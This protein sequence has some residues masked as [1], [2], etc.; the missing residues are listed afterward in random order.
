MTARLE[1]LR[2]WAA[3]HHPDHPLPELEVVAD[4]ASFRRYFRLRFDNGDSRIL[5][6]APPE[7]ENS[8]SFVEIAQR[9]RDNGVRVPEL[10]H[11]D[12]DAGFIELQDLGND[13][14]RERLMQGSSSDREP[15][16]AQALALSVE[17]AGQCSDRLPVMDRDWL[18]SELDLF[19]QWC[20]GRWLG[21]AGPASWQQVRE[22]LIEA[23]TAQPQVCVHRDLHAQNLMLHDGELWV[24][25]FQGAMRGPLGYDLA[26]LLRDRNHP[27]SEDEQQRWIEQWRLLA[28]ERGTIDRLEPGEPLESEALR[29]MVDL[30]GAQ[31]SLKVLGLFCRLALRD[32]K[33]RYLAMLPLFAE[34]VRQGL[35][36]HPAFVDFMQ[37]FD[38]ELMPALNARLLAWHESLARQE[39]MTP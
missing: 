18:G 20:L 39:P 9:W 3:A 27:W 16:M 1:A 23:L 5:M 11:S 28:I 34:H 31:R 22:H 13:M 2:H 17:I 14:L 19:P 7:Q 4:D 36:G 29:R 15:L 37:W 6:D 30:A 38:S 33:P 35:S 10:H 12:L 21:M 26:S 8:R 25:D 24:I 32:D